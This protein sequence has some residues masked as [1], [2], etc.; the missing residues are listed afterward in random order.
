MD[1][2]MLYFALVSQVEKLNIHNVSYNLQSII[3]ESMNT[4][5]KND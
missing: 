4:I 5:D 3:L 1:V 2:Y